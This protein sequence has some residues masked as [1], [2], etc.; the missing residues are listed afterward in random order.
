MSWYQSGQSIPWYTQRSA[1]SNW[2]TEPERRDDTH[3]EDHPRPRGY[4]RDRR[5]AR[6][7]RIGQRRRRATNL[8]FERLV[9]DA[10]RPRRVLPGSRCAG[11]TD[12]TGWTVGGAG[13]DIV[14]KSFGK[15]T[16]GSRSIDL[17]ASRGRLNQPR[18][19]YGARPDVRRVLLDVWQS[20]AHAVRGPKTMDVSAAD[21]DQ[22]RDSPTTRHDAEHFRGHEV[23]A[24]DLLVCRDRC[25]D[26]A[27]LHEHDHDTIGQFADRTAQRVAP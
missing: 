3:E 21:S 6:P 24:G 11:A 8:S 15:P 20:A 13:V 9:R 7:R 10:H 22:P 27:D 2:F 16:T 17:N 25:F 4:R 23:Q 5:P 12:L 1:T 26:H 14:D 19:R 18:H